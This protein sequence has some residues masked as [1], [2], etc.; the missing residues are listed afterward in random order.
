MLT[1]IDAV[2]LAQENQT[3]TDN[4]LK[5][6][7]QILLLDLFSKKGAFNNLIFKG[8]T[9]LRLVYKSY[10]F[11]EDL[12]FSIDG[13]FSF[14]TFKKLIQSIPSTIIESKVKDLDNKRYTFFSRVVFTAEYK[15][16]P[17]GIK[18]E[19][20]K[21]KHSIISEPGIAK[22]P[23]NNIN[24]VVKV[25][26]LKSILKDKMEILEKEQRR[27]PRDLFDAWFINQKLNN[28]FKIKEEYKY[29]KND[30]MNKLNPF[31]PNTLAY[32]LEYFEKK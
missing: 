6:H 16:I 22:S 1:Q 27:E 10:R 23:F 25:A 12:D 7:Y 26:S 4:V 32:I 17:I 11:S 5:E 13:D 2:Q 28:T 21:E 31:I 15:P 20:N 18:I 19:I 24:P 3:N 29:D 8:G 30:L 14:D 9:A